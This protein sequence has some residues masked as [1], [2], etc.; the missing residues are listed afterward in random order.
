M[1]IFSAIIHKIDK[2]QSQAPSLQLSLQ[3]LTI[4]EQVTILGT[5][6]NNAFRKDE[7]VLKTEFLSNPNIFQNGARTFSRNL[8]QD[9]FLDFSRSSIHRMIDLMTGNNLATGGYFVYLYYNYRNQNFLGVFMVRDEE[10]LIFKRKA[11]NSTFEVNS[12]TVVNTNKLA[13][14]VRVNID[15]ISDTRYLHFTKKQAHLSQY[16]FDWIEADLAPKNSEDAQHLIDL[17]HHLEPGELP[18]NP[19]TNERLNPD[20][21]KTRFY[22]NIL[23]TGRMVRLTDLGSTFWNDENFLINKFEEM[24]V[25]ISTEFQAPAKILRKL[26]K[27]ELKS[28]RLRL[29]FSQNDISSGRVALN[30][31]STS[32]IITDED[33]ITQFNNL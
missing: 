16:F 15:N 4:E 24:G 23:S 32:L 29:V 5:R 25:E 33:L 3:S 13:M 26:M 27:Y 6:L 28:G 14:A 18:I 22:D 2:E 31:E 7:N 10:E 11:D 8:T 20:E 1:E 12:T 19:E 9:S 17:I 21:F 30:D